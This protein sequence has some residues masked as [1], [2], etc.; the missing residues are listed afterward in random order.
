MHVPSSFLSGALFRVHVKSYCFLCYLKQANLNLENTSKLHFAN[1]NEDW[2]LKFKEIGSNT[3]R[4][5][6]DMA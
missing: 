2:I 4:D 6:D 1:N 5:C 3:N